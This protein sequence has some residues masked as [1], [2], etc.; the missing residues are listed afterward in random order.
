MKTFLRVAAL[1]IAF[2]PLAGAQA[3]S[4]GSNQAADDAMNWA[5]VGG[6][7]GGAYGSYEQG[8]YQ[9]RHWR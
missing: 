8:R 4:Q 6:R 5:A 1:A 3:Q 7:H 2:L 9:Q